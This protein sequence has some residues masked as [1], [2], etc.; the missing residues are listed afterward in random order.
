MVTVRVSARTAAA[1]DQDES[2][3]VAELSDET[4]SFPGSSW[5]SRLVRV[6]AERF[7]CALLWQPS[8]AWTTH[9]ELVLLRPEGLMRRPAKFYFESDDE[10]ARVVYELNEAAKTIGV[11]PDLFV[12]SHS[13]C[14]VVRD[15]RVYVSI[16]DPLASLREP[17]RGKWQS[18]TEYPIA[19]VRD[20][21]TDGAVVEVQLRTGA[22]VRTDF[23]DLPER[24]VEFLELLRGEGEQTDR[25]DGDSGSFVHQLERLAELHAQGHL[26][27]KEFASAKRKLLKGR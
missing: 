26:S 11:Y 20:I 25:Q 5:R 13:D 6:E 10:A 27:E 16:I 21:R 2:D 18:S 8:A 17:A 1:G 4:F 19:D 9:V 14:T 12:R 7:V 22:L 24:R 3:F 15:G 23:T